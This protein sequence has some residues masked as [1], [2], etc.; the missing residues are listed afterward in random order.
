MVD[1]PG[2]AQSGAIVPQ[3]EYRDFAS[4]PE[5]T[6]R[7]MV[8]AKNSRVIL[9]FI[10]DG[11]V[12]TPQQ[13]ADLLQGVC[14]SGKGQNWLASSGT[15][16]AVVANAADT[17]ER[18]IESVYTAVDVMQGTLIDMS[19]KLVREIVATSNDGKVHHA[20]TTTYRAT[21]NYVPKQSTPALPASQS[22]DSQPQGSQPQGRG[23]KGNRATQKEL[24]KAY[25]AGLKQ[26]YR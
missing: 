11:S 16:L 7:F 13:S 25:Q 3:H 1:T 2:S 24:F 8:N 19:Q 12:T 21:R 18:K 14:Q 10:P 17:P 9:G 15:I 22:Q 4:N 23:P 6:R 5:V 26:A 20:A